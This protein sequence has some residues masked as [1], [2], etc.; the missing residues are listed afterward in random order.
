MRHNASTSI[1]L[2]Y[3]AGFG[4]GATSQ[5]FWENVYGFN[6]SCIGK[7]VAEDAAKTAI[8]DIVDSRDIVTESA[9][10]KVSYCFACLTL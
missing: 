3:I 5:P 7:E 9:A 8:V 1:L 10:L 2:Q 4:R 6:M